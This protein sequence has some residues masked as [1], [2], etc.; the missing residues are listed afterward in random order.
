MP[1]EV[2]PP[3]P[4]DSSLIVVMGAMNPLVHSPQFY[5][6][7]GAMDEAE[8]QGSLKMPLNS[9]TA[10]GSSFQFG[11]PV[12]S[13]NVQPGQW[14]IQ[15]SN[16]ESWERML[17]ITRLVFGK[18]G[19][20]PM[21]AYS[22]VSQRHIDTAIPSVKATLAKR[23]AAMGLGF[24]DGESVASNIELVVKEEDYL[25]TT[26]VQPSVLGEQSVYTY[27]QRHYS[28]PISPSGTFALEPVVRSRLQ[29]FEE[30][31][32]RFFDAAI[33]GISSVEVTA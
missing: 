7:V 14:W 11:S 23:I 3:R 21:N 2:T 13:I 8:L 1:E 29:A 31:S 15:S 10:E 6:S 32:R 22:L 33:A 12:F 30:A 25:V 20:T 18:L 19:G 4:R 27:Y 17:M 26:S 16:L 24:A 28:V 9:T 5:R